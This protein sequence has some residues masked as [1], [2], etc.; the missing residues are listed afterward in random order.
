MPG[1]GGFSSSAGRSGRIR[2]LD[3]SKMGLSFIPADGRRRRKG[4]SV[5]FLKIGAPQTF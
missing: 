5:V 3:V 2:R 1:R 4:F